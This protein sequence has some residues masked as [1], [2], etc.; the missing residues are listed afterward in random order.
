MTTRHNALTYDF[1]SVLPAPFAIV[2]IPG[3]DVTLSHRGGYLQEPLTMSVDA[4]ALSKYPI[5]NSQYQVFADANDGYGDPSWW[6]FSD[7]AREWWNENPHPLKPYGGDDHPRTHV[8]WYEAVAYCQW[9]AA[10]TGL[11]IHL[12]SEAQWQRAAQGD[13]GRPYPWGDNW[14]IALC[15]NNV[16]H[17]GIGTLSVRTHEGEGDSPY[18]VVDMIGNVWEWCATSWESGSDDLSLDEVRVLRGGS[19]FDDVQ[20]AFRADYR[21]SWNPELASDL[22]GF[23]IAVG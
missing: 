11:D 13:D 9:L 8:T 6:E 4:F 20:N 1:A 3:G 23:R 21:S 19:W 5:T 7:T 15:T 14:D 16:A 18:G 22:R 17:E 10:K 12:P 2:V